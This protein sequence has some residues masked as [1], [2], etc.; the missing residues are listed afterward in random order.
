MFKR[1]NYQITK[2]ENNIKFILLYIY[3]FFFILNF[4]YKLK[5]SSKIALKNK[6][7]S[8]SKLYL[9]MSSY[10]MPLHFRPFSG[11]FN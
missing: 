1:K 11:P 5:H 9:D 4:I 3:I 10:C 2:K 7:R 6:T 8:Y